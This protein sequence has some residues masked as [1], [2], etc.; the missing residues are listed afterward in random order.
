MDI[1]EPVSDRSPAAPTCCKPF[2]LLE[3]EPE[4]LRL[5]V[6]GNQGKYKALECSGMVRI[7]SNDLL[8]QLRRFGEASSIFQELGAII[9]RI[10][11]LL[12]GVRERELYMQEHSEHRYRCAGHQSFCESHQDT[13]GYA[14]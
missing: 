14:G 10:Q 11:F 8:E 1:G 4:P 6:F 13:H 2:K 9:V 3:R 5:S 7:R 12:G